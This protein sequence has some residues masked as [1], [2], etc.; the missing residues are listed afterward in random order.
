[1]RKLIH[2]LARDNKAAT[3]VEYGLIAALVAVAANAALQGV[4][5]QVKKTTGSATSTVRAT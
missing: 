5:T 4:S 1:M 2:A 3:A